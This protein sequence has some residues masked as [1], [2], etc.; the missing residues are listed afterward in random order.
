LLLAAV[1]T[2]LT[3]CS[4][5][6]SPATTPPPPS[7]LTVPPTS[8]TTAASAVQDLPS[9]TYVDGRP[10][11]PHYFMT[12]TTNPDNTLS[13]NVSFIYQDGHTFSVFAFT[14]TTQSGSVSINMGS[15][16]GALTAKYENRRFILDSCLTYLG[17]VQ[18]AD[19]CTFVYSPTGAQ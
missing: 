12:L 17:L 3:G 18:S 14:A 19:A 1:I 13:G 4:Q 15:T 7:G 8:G 10:G 11:T 6:Q 2:A 16:Q 5:N 9:G